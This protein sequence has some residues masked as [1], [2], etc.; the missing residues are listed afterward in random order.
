MRLYLN[1]LT[2]FLCPWALWLGVC[3]AASG[4]ETQANVMTEITFTASRPHTDPFNGVTL[5]VVFAEP[6]GR[7]LRVPA[8]WAGGNLWKVRYA[9]PV[10]GTHRFRTECSDAT[11][12]GLHGVKGK[13]IIKP[14]TGDN[15]LFRH[16]PLRASQNRRYLEHQD[17]TPFF[18][19]GDTWWMGLSHRLHFPD[20]FQQLAQDRIQKGFTVIQI[21]AGLYP[22][23]FP[24]DPRGA[25]EAGFPWETNYSSIRPQYFDAA[26]QRIE[27]LVAHGLT[28]CIVGAWGYFMPWM[29]VEKMKSH[30]RYLIARY[31]AMPVVWC[32][33]GEANLPWYLAKGFPYDDRKQVSDWTEVMRFI[34]DTDP[35][36]HLLTVH[37]TGIGRLSARHA[38]DDA[39]LLDIDLLQTPHGRREAVPVTIDT[40]RQSYADTPVMPVI[41]GE[42]SYEMLGDSLPTEWTRRMFWI[43]MMNGAAGHTYGANGI[44]QC[45]RPGDPHG[46]SPHGGTYGKIPWN[47]AMLLPGSEQ[48]GFGKRLF[49]QY[50]WQQFQPHPEW[51]AWAGEAQSDD[52]GPQSCGI[53]GIVRV[54]Y[55]PE[56][57]PV[58]SRGLGVHA[59][60]AAAY[61]DPV[62]GKRTELGAI[63]AD[64]SGVW[65]C[66]SPPGSTHDWVLIVEKK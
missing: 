59:A 23:M 43:C 9:S 30:W 21:V 1:R 39:A 3:V 55:A 8:F 13:I 34:R 14:Y 56:S 36:H 57:R 17:G 61:F 37:P 60:C 47:E 65:I 2:Q 22:D 31:G 25:N 27:Y 33:A 4:A 32:A 20:E 10:V 50:A 24:F 15:P 11:D 52:F 38:T 16:G 12:T 49:T 28:P 18:W 45:N 7:E 58:V 35:F 64:D 62:S 48:V 42:A 66:P 41:D 51:A 46:K 6:H 5:D 63:H 53:P 54:T 19:L 26:D 29:G 44:W 40:V